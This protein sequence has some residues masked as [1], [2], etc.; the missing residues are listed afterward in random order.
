MNVGIILTVSDYYKDLSPLPGCKKDYEVINKILQ[1]SKKYDKIFIENEKTDAAVV[2][3]KL[4][5]FIEGLN[6]DK[7]DEVLFYYSGHGGFDGNDFYY[8]FSNYEKNKKKQTSLENSELDNLLKKL[9]PDIT[10]KIV[11]ACQSGI[12]YVKDNNNFEIYLKGTQKEFKKCYFYFSSHTNQSSYQDDELSFFT[13]S[14]IE[15]I[16]HHSQSSIRYKD[17]IDYITDTFKNPN[18]KPYFVVQADFTEVFGDYSATSR[19]ELQ[20]IL[21]NYVSKEIE[22]AI[23]EQND[24]SLFDKIKADAE[25]FCTEKDAL[26]VLDK[27]KSQVESL[28]MTEELEQLYNIDFL[29]STSYSSIPNK[30]QIGK[31]FDQN[32]HNY[33]AKPVKSERRIEKNHFGSTAIELMALKGL[34][35]DRVEYET[36]IDGVEATTAMPYSSI[37]IEL[38]KNYPNIN[39]YSLVFIPFLSKTEIIIFSVII[40]YKDK[41]WTERLVSNYDD[42]KS[43]V[44]KIKDSTKIT[45]YIDSSFKSFINKISSSLKS[46]YETLNEDK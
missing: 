31:W 41:G 27:I 35:S 42:F 28:K 15:S 43:I 44:I 16:A 46:K 34:Y 18:Q 3:Q 10:V 40:M 24:L 14:F 26:E 2:K 19:K 20:D 37:I 32:S 38:K 1:L 11:D 17:I 8:L 29:T 12:N 30:V 45:E 33:F 22:T 39:E 13:K 5:D 21:S 7:V 4:I 25:M 36:F 23:S 6:T 9:N